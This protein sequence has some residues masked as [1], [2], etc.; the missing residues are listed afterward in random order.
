MQY[1]SQKQPK[2]LTKNNSSKSESSDVLVTFGVFVLFL[3]SIS[4]LVVVI[5]NDYVI[6]ALPL[7]EFTREGLYVTFRPTFYMLI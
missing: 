1:K 2:Q 6:V 5:V 4:I 7:P 3:L